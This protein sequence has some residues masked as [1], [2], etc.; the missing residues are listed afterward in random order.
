MRKGE[1]G[2]TYPLTLMLLL[3][4]LLFF[5][6]KIEWLLSER[7]MAHEK[8]AIL[9]EEYYYLSSVKKIEKLYQIGTVIPLKST[10]NFSK[11]NMEYQSEKPVG[12][13]QKINFTLRL[14]TGET[15][16]ARGYFDTSSKKLAKWIEMK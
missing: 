9:L 14:N 8:S 5:S 12:T 1:K 6:V 13:V 2:F 16:I 7:K 10:I 4:F 3:L 11:G 15:T